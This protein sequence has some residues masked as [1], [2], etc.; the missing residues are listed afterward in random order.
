MASPRCDECGAPAAEGTASCARCGAALPPPDDLPPVDGPRA[1][2]GWALASRSTLGYAAAQVAVLALSGA[3]GA[4][5]WRDAGVR[6]A[7]ITPM[8]AVPMIAARRRSLGWLG[9]SAGVL[10]ASVAMSAALMALGRVRGGAL[11]AVTFS[12]AALWSVALSVAALR[13]RG[14]RR[15]AAPGPQPP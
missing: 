5:S 11:M 9:A 14:D 2:A 3:T 10:L 1:L 8:I 13:V 7:L 4:T 15:P 6:A 12:T